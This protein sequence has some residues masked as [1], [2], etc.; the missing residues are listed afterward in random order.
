MDGEDDGLEEEEAYHANA[1]ANANPN[2]TAN[3]ED[4]SQMNAEDTEVRESLLRNTSSQKAGAAVDTSGNKR[5]RKAID[6]TEPENQSS[7]NSQNQANLQVADIGQQNQV[8]DSQVSH[9]SESTAVTESSVDRPVVTAP[10][11]TSQ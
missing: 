5:K 8:L 6:D 4:D 11:A 2:G 3:A 10:E 7:G 1:A 9:V